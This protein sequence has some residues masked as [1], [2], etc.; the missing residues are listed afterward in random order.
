MQRT[1]Q[2]PFKK[3]DIDPPARLKSLQQ[4]F[5]G[6][7]SQPLNPDG[8]ISAMTPAGSSTTTEASKYISPGHKLK[9]HE[10][11]QIYSQQCW[12]R[13]YSTFHSTFPLLTR[14]FGRDDF[15]RSIATPYMQCYPSQNWSLHWLGDRL[16]HW[17]KE[18]YIGDDKP[19][20]YHA[21]VVDWC[22]LHCQIAA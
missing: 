21:A 4:W 16:P 22:Y 20:V 19:L 11:I 7:I 18:H 1:K 10:R 6:I 9:P 15:N 8:T 5:A 14:L 13:F 3:R 12:W 17:I 2:P